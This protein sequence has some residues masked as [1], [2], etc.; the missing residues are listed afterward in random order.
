MFCSLAGAVAAT[1]EI[2][3]CADWGQIS[4]GHRDG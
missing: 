4:K 3:P 1:S 2:C